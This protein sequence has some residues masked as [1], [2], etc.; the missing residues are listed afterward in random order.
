M[1]PIKRSDNKQAKGIPTTLACEDLDPFIGCLTSELF[2]DVDTCADGGPPMCYR[3]RL[4][5]ELLKAPGQLVIQS[6][7]F[8]RLESRLPHWSTLSWSA[9]IDPMPRSLCPN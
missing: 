4:K 5:A 6:T 1:L 3:T 9:R 8:G 2:L 7:G